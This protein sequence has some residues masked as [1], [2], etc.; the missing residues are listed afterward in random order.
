M[1]PP[2][3]LILDGDLGFLLALSQE[4]SHRQ[5]L[6]VPARTSREAYSMLAGFNLEP[7]LLVVD[8]SAPGADRLVKETARKQ[9]GVHIVAFVSEHQGCGDCANLLSA[10]LRD[11]EDKA[12]DR[13]PYCAD[14]MQRLV[15]EQALFL[16][17][18]R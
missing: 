12:A 1:V 17:R 18:G 16:V 6:A 11:P 4:L 8:C 2:T 13:I 15:R 14:V 5:M 3:I 10:R 7:D 9:P